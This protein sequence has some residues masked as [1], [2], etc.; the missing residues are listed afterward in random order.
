MAE[1]KTKPT[2]QNPAD[3][4]NSL[5]DERVRQDCRQIVEWMTEATGEAAVMWGISIVGFGS[6]PYT[7]TTGSYDWPLIG[8]SPRKQD[9]TLYLMNGFEEYEVLLS[10]LGKHK[11]GKACLYIKKLADVDGAVLQE[12]IQ[13]SVDAVRKQGGPA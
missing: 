10:R 7:N 6:Q 2:D 11:H 8:F 13:S 12:L 3:F 5:P 9:L 4:I 1:P